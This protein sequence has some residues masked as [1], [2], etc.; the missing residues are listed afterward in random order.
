MS[1]TLDQLIDVLRRQRDVR[2]GRL[3]L[4]ESAE[5]RVGDQSPDVAIADAKRRLKD[6]VKKMDSLILDYGRGLH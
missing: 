5:L 3:D 1:E 2:M 6:I 4:L